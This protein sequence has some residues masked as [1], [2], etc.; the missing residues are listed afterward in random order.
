MS[1]IKELP[2]A[3]TTR[4]CVDRLFAHERF[5][6]HSKSALRQIEY[7]RRGGDSDEEIILKLHRL[8]IEE[9]AGLVQEGYPLIDRVDD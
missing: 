9:L 7:L 8:N 5:T 3:S 1:E 4:E 2:F 6:S